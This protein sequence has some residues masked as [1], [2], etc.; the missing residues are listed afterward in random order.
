MVRKIGAAYECYE[1]HFT[2]NDFDGNMLQHFAC[3]TEVHVFRA[4]F[5]MQVSKELH[6]RRIYA[7][8]KKIWGHLKPT[9]LLAVSA[10]DIAATVGG[11]GGD[12]TKFYKKYQQS[13]VD[14][15][16][17]GTMLSALVG[18]SDS[19]VEKLLLDLDIASFFQSPEDTGVAK[20]FANA[21]FASPNSSGRIQRHF[22]SSSITVSAG[23]HCH[24]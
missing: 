6:C 2:S 7:E 17:D 12:A 24:P 13:F 1:E 15:G 8:F 23:K 19:D 22:R 18:V 3:R 16:F 9:P 21:A 4:I 5:D 10:I 14:N 20:R 11:L